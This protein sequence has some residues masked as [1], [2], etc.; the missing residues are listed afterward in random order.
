MA[1]EWELSIVVVLSGLS[2]P[3]QKEVAQKEVA[4]DAAFR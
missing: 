3:A 2:Q 1:G 4:E